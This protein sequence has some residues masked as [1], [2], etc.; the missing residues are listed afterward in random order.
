MKT[1]LLSKLSLP[2]KGILGFATKKMLSEE[3]NGDIVRKSSNLCW[4]LR[5]RNGENKVVALESDSRRRKCWSVG[6]KQKI[7]KKAEP[8]DNVQCLPLF[9][10]HQGSYHRLELLI[11]RQVNYFCYEGIIAL[12]RTYLTE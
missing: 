1:R 9:A 7:D 5:R 6:V 8:L 4:A 10:L 12:N 3:G 2:W 11:T